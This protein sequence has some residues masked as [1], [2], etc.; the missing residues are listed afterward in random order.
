M[1]V[2]LIPVLLAARGGPLARP[3]ITGLATFVLTIA[4]LHT[5]HLAGGNRVPVSKIL[6]P[7]TATPDT[8]NCDQIRQVLNEAGLTLDRTDPSGPR[9]AGPLAYQIPDQVKEAIAACFAVPQAN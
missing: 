1:A 4:A 5:S 2:V 8:E 3:A 6:E 7:P 9:L